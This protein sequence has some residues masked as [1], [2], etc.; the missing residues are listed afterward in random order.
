LAGNPE[1][2]RKKSSHRPMEFGFNDS[3]HEYDENISD[4]ETHSQSMVEF[5]KTE[6][7]EPQC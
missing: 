1:K 5:V 4:F 3:E 7:S 2:H 6:N